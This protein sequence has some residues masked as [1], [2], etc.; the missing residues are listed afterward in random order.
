CV[1]SP[2]N[3]AASPRKRWRRPPDAAPAAVP[4]AD[5]LTPINA[6]AGA[7]GQHGTRTHRREPHMG[8][9]L[10]GRTALVTG[11]GRGR[12]AAVVRRPHARVATVAVRG[13]LEAEGRALGTE[14]GPRGRFFAEDVTDAGGRRGVVEATLTGCG[15]LDV[16]V[17]NAG[18]DA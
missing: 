7:T 1:K 16:L 17:S 8:T 3:A 12:G 2:S 13:R 18:I 10:T 11:G 4:A 5:A 15:R 9:P 6:P 14:L